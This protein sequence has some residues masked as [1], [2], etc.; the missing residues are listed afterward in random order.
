M[1]KQ[2][3]LTRVTRKVAFGAAAITVLACS[4]MLTGCKKQEAGVVAAKNLTSKPEAKVETYQSGTNNGFFWSL[5]KS[6]GATGTVNYANGAA[7]NYSVNWNGFNGNFT[8]GKGYSA[9][10]ATYKIGYNLS[11]YSNSGGGTFGWY[12]WSRSPYYEYYVN[13]TW[14]T[15]SPHDGT[16][17]GTFESDGAGYNVWTRLMT[18]KNIDGGDG[19]RQI[20]SSKVNKT[21][22]KQ[23]HVITFANHYQK[24]KSLGYTLG[25]LNIPA[26]MVSETWGSNTNGN[27]NCTIWAQ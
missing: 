4:T 3:S 22:T 18:G 7:G 1:K 15:V 12:G 11:A 23:N 25:Q 20:Y 8:C 27:I 9:G 13:E 10:S 5:W 17:L 2:N 16:Y 19:F 26:I 6:D 21:S 24:W 14:G